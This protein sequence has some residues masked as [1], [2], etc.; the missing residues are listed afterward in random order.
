MNKDRKVYRV[1]NLQDGDAWDFDTA[2]D[3]ALH[4]WGRWPIT[5]YAIFK[6]RVRWGRRS[7]GELEKW[8]QALERWQPD[9]DC[10]R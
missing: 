4:L 1:V 5:D 9:Q 7:G 3:V 2:E 10:V 8:K 6:R